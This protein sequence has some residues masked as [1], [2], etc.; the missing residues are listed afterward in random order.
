MI[1]TRKNTLRSTKLAVSK[2]DIVTTRKVPGKAD[3]NSSTRRGDHRTASLRTCTAAVA[4]PFRG[5]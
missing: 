4:M 3:S 5:S 2:V 1:A